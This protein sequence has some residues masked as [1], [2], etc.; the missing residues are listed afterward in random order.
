VSRRHRAHR[1]SITVGAQ[2][3]SSPYDPVVRV[4]GRDLLP[5]TEV[6]DHR[7]ARPFRFVRA[8]TT[9]AD[10][11]VLDFIGGQAGHECWRSFYPE[12]VKTV[13]RIDRT[14][15]NAAG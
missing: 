8:T 14:R 5:G 6:S 9:S 11:I 3:D 10:R 1:G 15:H 13:H 2:P 7:R 12:R 4:R